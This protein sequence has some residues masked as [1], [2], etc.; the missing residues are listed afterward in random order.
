MLG[1]MMAL[2]PC[3]IMTDSS[4]SALVR[5]FVVYLIDMPPLRET[6]SVFPENNASCRTRRVLGVIG[7]NCDLDSG[8]EPEVFEGTDV[9]EVPIRPLTTYGVGLA[10]VIGRLVLD[11]RSQ[12]PHSL[13]TVSTMAAFPPSNQRASTMLLKPD[14]AALVGAGFITRVHRPWVAARSE[15]HSNTRTAP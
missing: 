2:S 13:S 10:P 9:V 1:M 12:M 7:A 3:Q 14:E 5:E 4:V 8:F 6:E 11:D 15:Q